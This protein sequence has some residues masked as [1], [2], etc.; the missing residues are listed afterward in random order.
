MVNHLPKAI[1]LSTLAVDYEDSFSFKQFKAEV[2]DEI[3]PD[4]PG[5][6]CRSDKDL[7]TVSYKIWK[8]NKETQ[9]LNQ[10]MC[11]LTRIIFT[12]RNESDNKN[13]NVLEEEYASFQKL[14]D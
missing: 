4:G 7:I 5:A 11:S 14:L 10:V 8:V 13:C 6:I 1:K 12:Y 3:H 2:F 9:R